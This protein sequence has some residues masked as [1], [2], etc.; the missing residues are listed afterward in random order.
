[1][2]A[3]TTEAFVLWKVRHVEFLWKYHVRD[4]AEVPSVYTEG[5]ETL[6]GPYSIVQELII[7]RSSRTSS[8][9]RNLTG[10]SKSFWSNLCRHVW[11]EPHLRWVRE[12]RWHGLS[13][14]NRLR[15]AI[16]PE[17]W[18]P[19]LPLSTHAGVQGMA[20]WAWR[21]PQD[22]QTERRGLDL[23]SQ[24]EQSEQESKNEGMG[25]GSHL[26]R[27]ECRQEPDLGCLWINNIDQRS[28]IVGTPHRKPTVGS[29]VGNNF[30]KT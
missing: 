4:Q 28:W 20:A 26:Q 21:L 30:C 8:E 11:G 23:R 1:M 6:N 27:R 29:C 12:T 17:H 5:G 13:N 15:T 16:Q 9:R 25:L 18:G 7:R 24:L 19:E 3:G 14:M 10:Q 22:N 2:T